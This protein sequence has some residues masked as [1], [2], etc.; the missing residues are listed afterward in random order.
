[1][2]AMMMSALK[3]TAREDGALRRRQVHHVE[4]VERGVGRRERGGDDR[5]VLRDVVGDAERRQRAARHQELLA[6]LDD[7]D[8][9][10]RVRV[11]V[12]HVAG[13]LRRLGAGVHRHGD[14]GLGERGGVVRAVAGHRDEAAARLVLADE[15]ELRLRRRLREVV[16]DAGLGGDR[17]GG[18]RVVAGDHHG[19]DAHPPQLGE[20][21]L[22]A[23]F[24]DVLQLDDAEHRGPLGDDERRPAALGD[25]LDGA[26]TSAGN[27]PPFACT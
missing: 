27:V 24:D 18:Q 1:M 2:R 12:D 17:G 8:E 23:P 13:L 26:R 11:E 21:L 6:D 19:L 10:R 4:R 9:L 16:V 15:R 3:M 7:L 20:A 22:D 5:E 14:V 25:R